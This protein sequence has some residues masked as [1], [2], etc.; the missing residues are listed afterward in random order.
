MPDWAQA[1][2]ARR[3]HVDR[4]ALLMGDWAVG[5]GLDS[6]DVASWR[7]AGVLHD[8]LRDADPESLR[9]G[10]PPALRDLP[11]SVLHGPAAAERLRVDGVE[12]SAFLL[13]V[14]YHTL[15]HPEL[16]ARGMALYVADFLEPG[17]DLLN[18]WRGELRSRMP[19]DLTEVAREI[20]AARITHLIEDGR[21][22]RPETVAFWNTLSR[23]G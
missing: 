8:A 16:D 6:E 5:L 18:E 12:D 15:G 4:V 7:A 2:P 11:A 13:A 23:E 21:R 20:L 14:A 9:T 1:S 3:E 10:V 22:M 17:R 19:G